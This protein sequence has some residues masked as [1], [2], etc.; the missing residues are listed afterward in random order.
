MNAALLEHLQGPLW[1][2]DPRAL[3]RFVSAVQTVDVSGFDPRAQANAGGDLYTVDGDV[4]TIRIGGVMMRRVPPIYQWFG[5]VFGMEFADIERIREAVARAVEDS[6]IKSLDLSIDSPGGTT[7]G[8]EALAD[9]IFAARELKPV[10]THVD[11]LMASA[12]LYVGVQGGRV[13][14]R[15]GDLVGSI[16][17]FAVVRDKSKAAADAGVKVHV[18]SNAPGKGWA[19]G[20]PISEEMLANLQSMVDGYAKQFV[21]AVA[22]GRGM[23]PAAAQALATGKLWHADEAQTLG[24]IDAVEHDGRPAG[25]DANTTETANRQNPTTVAEAKPQESIMATDLEKAQALAA[26]EKARA[27]LAVATLATVQGQRRD[28]LVTKY[29]DRISAENKASVLD[30]AKFCNGDFVKFEAHLESLPVLTRQTEQGADIADDA[31]PLGKAEP[32]RG[33]KQ[34]AKI[35]GMS[36][37]KIEKLGQRGTTIASGGVLSIPDP[38]AEDG[39]REIAREDIAAYLSDAPAVVA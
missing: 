36:H 28:E 12:S 9:D 14:A 27:D 1:M 25:N 21:D 2:I 34:V 3:E 22:R 26:E 23:K 15:R 10:T 37:A 5:K 24:L 18:I 39:V 20:A 35:F 7:A 38:K 30:Y 33:E 8:L 4:A 19:D 11:G 13:T 16:G 17:T 29:Q 6:R 32:T 31:R